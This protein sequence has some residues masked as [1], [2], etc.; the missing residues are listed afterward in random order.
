MKQLAAKTQRQI[1][2]LTS[3]TAEEA[4]RLRM[5]MRDAGASLERRIEEVR[6][7]ALLVDSESRRRESRRRTPTIISDSHEDMAQQRGTTR[8][9]ASEV[10]TS[11][12]G[13]RPVSLRDARSAICI[14][15]N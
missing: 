3:T 8:S 9:Y 2:N 12:G 15:G 1:E 5:E 11:G 7:I 14:Q 10:A 13:K 4:G 6:G